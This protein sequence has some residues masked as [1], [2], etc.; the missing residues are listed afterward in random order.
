MSGEASPGDSSSF[1]L[2]DDKG[3]IFGVVN[4]IDALVVLLVLAVVIAGIVFLT[5]DVE[6]DQTHAT[7]DLGTMPDHI[8]TQVTEGDSYEPEG[9]NANLTITDVH[10]TY[11]GD[12]THVAVRVSLEGEEVDDTLEYLGEPPRLDRELTIETG[13]YEV[14]GTIQAVGEGDQLTRETIQVVVRDTMAVDEARMIQPDDE[15]GVGV[16][17]MGTVDEIARFQTDDPEQRDVYVAATLEAVVIGG[18]IQYGGIPVERNT[19]VTLRTAA[20]SLEGPTQA[21]G[22]GLQ[23]QTM[24]VVLHDTVTAEETE[25][26]QS[27]DQV[28]LGG[29]TIA[30]FEDV[31][32]HQTDDPDEYHATVHAEIA[33]LGFG[34]RPIYAGA[35]VRRG[36]ELSFLQPEYEL[37][38]SIERT[39]TDLQRETMD[40][41]LRETVTA[42]EAA[43]IDAGTEITAGGQTVASF[44]DVALHQTDDPDEYIATIHAEVDTLGYG[45][46]PVYGNTEVRRDSQ[47][48]VLHPDYELSTSIERTGTDLQRETMDVILE[49]TVTAAEALEIQTGS[50][51]TVGEQTVVSFEDVA[52]YPTD[53]PE[54]RT[55]VIHAEVD[56]LGYGERPIYAG[57]EI[58]RDGQLPVLHPEYEL[59][60][61]IERTGTTLQTSQ[62]EVV[63]SDTISA[64]DAAELQT[65]DEIVVGE[66]T[67]VSIEDIAIY[68]TTA[69]EQHEVYVHA[70]VGVLEYGERP[71]IGTDPIGIGES[72]DLATA[73]VDLTA[74]IEAFDTDLQREEMEVLVSDTL[75]LEA[76]ESIVTNDSIT[77]AG[78]ETAVVREHTLYGT[79]DPDVKDAFVG[80]SLETL[81]FGEQPLFAGAPVDTGESVYLRSLGYEIDGTIERL[82]ALTERGEPV[83]ET[84]TFEVTNVHQSTAD[85]LVEGLTEAQEGTAAATVQSVT[86]ENSTIVIE[87]EDGSLGVH[88]HPYERDVT[89]EVELNAREGPEGI[90]YQGDPLYHGASVTFDFG[91][92]TVDADVKSVT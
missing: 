75:Q 25:T 5:T 30:T 90:R 41:V 9:A 31:A 50:E 14:N 87:G 53:D 18:V 62:R 44:E 29:D 83:T 39:G 47:L 64:T 3:R 12:Q 43:A 19:D 84:V 23:E 33:A 89:F 81:N 51:I 37:S 28:E 22:T 11:A 69:P 55:A 34:E 60:A 26:I 35:E 67:A 54:L 32:F 27:G 58:R 13:L 52:L 76:A 88:E 24:D 40:V 68:Q 66:Y 1:S 92:I 20:Y 82:D 59:S 71:R 85:E 46:R 48:S 56:T 36:G 70:N 91:S 16:H 74:T 21:V 61:S 49:D 4:I 15:L 78:D 80:V 45:E 72:V 63:F 86:V 73:E 57:E 79:L 6:A 42:A 10:R 7:L 8:A 2:I 77:A 65:L 38:A 17:T